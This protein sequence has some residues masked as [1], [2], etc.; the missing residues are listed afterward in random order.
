[1]VF[2]SRRNGS[3][4]IYGFSLS[5]NEEFAFATGIMVGQVIQGSTD[6]DNGVDVTQHGYND[7]VDTW[8][9]FVPVSTDKYT[10]S[11]CGSDFDTTLAVF[12]EDL[13]EVEFNDNFCM[14]QSK[15]ILRGK[16]GKKY[17]VR[18]AGYDGESGNYNFSIIKDSPDPLRSDIN[19][20]G[21]VNMG[22]LAIM[23]SEWLANN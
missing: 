21:N 17:Y 12:D 3:G 11:V 4:N 13:V 6:D 15:L 8:H 10:I 18:I 20:D 19:Y 1:M 16:A 2:G 23:A 9:Y 22:D 5:D 7:V 14:Y